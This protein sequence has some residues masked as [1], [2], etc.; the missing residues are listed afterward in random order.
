MLR[1]VRE[2]ATAGEDEPSMRSASR[3]VQRNQLPD[4]YIEDSP[5]SLSG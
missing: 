1:K 2:K 5:Q 4:V 3:P